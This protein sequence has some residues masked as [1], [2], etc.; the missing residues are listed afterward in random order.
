MG[1]E[2]RPEPRGVS[3]TRDE[4]LHALTEAGIDTG[5]VDDQDA[6]T[7][8]EFMAMFNL[9]R[10]TAQHKLD[11]LAAAGKAAL[12]KKVAINSYGRRISQKAYRLT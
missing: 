8:A 4:W 10:N 9:G 6:V 2:L 11:A 7:V 1:A 12:T 3:I 5:A